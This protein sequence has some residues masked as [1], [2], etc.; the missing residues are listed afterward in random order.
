MDEL[1]VGDIVQLLEYTDDQL[2]R[3]LIESHQ[4]TGYCFKFENKSQHLNKYGKIDEVYREFVF[5]HSIENTP[6]AIWPICAIKK[7]IINLPID[8]KIE[9]LTAKVED[10]MHP[11][12][13]A[14]YNDRQDALKCATDTMDPKTGGPKMKEIIVEPTMQEKCMKTSDVLG[15]LDQQEKDLRK[16]CGY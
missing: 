14:F 3:A 15:M 8:A 9:M 16:Y 4:G 6:L 5:C 13:R 7:V 11:I 12:D 2:S 10:E 1:K